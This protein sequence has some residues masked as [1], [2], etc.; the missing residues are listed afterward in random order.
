[1]VAAAGTS[2]AIPVVV[3]VGAG[4]G[5]GA[6][7]ARRFGREGFGVGL[8]ARNGTRLAAAA[9]ELES[10]GVSVAFA[11]ADARDAEGLGE[12]LRDLAGRQGP[13]DV[14]CFC[15]L[16]DVSLIRPVLETTSQDLV[17]SLELVVGGAAAA[18]REVLPAMRRRGSGTMLFTTGSGALTPSHDRAASGVATTA[19]TVYYRML[20]DALAPKGIHVAHTVI[21]GAVGPGAQHEPAAVADHLWRRHVMRDQ[22]T[23]LIR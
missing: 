9:L 17:A 21:A 13:A 3:V 14:L 7:L 10:E 19:A 22:A 16:P 23:S 12:A 6:A 8:V 20:H 11:T 5:V 2:D 18:V 1:M 4:P 15:P